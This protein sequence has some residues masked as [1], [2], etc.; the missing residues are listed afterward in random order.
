M[1]IVYDF[2]AGDIS[3]ETFWA[4][5]INNPQIGQW[6]DQAG[7]F[8]SEL[9][10]D[11]PNDQQ[12]KVY[13][14]YIRNDHGGRVTETFPMDYYRTHNPYYTMETKSSIFGRIATVLLTIDSNVTRTKIYK[15]DE[16]YYD[17]AVTRS[18][19]GLEVENFI[20]RVLQQFP[21]TMKA[22]DR[23]KAGRAAIQEAFHIHDRKFP[24][25]PQEPDWPMGKN[26]PMEY[27]GRHKDGELV[28][29][30]FRDVD[31]GEEKIV[32]QFY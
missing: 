3:F 20:D 12:L 11:F 4:E 13:Y 19:G 10:T 14:R 22:A 30:R 8:R 23:V 29:L 26:S 6:L 31:T 15:Q 1:K 17:K 7:D 9:P 27:I 18:I 21:R 5:F 24:S 32:E 25:W 16:N 2:V 28:Q